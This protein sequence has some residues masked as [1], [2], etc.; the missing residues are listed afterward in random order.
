MHRQRLRVSPTNSSSGAVIASSRLRSRPLERVSVFLGHS[1]VKVTERQYASWVQKR[2]Q[3]EADLRSKWANERRVQI[4][5]TCR[6]CRGRRGAAQTF[7]HKMSTGLSRFGVGEKCIGSTL[8]RGS[9][10]PT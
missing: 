2:Q 1:S 4:R 6:T 10:L 3:L 5:Y 7:G 8:S 9:F